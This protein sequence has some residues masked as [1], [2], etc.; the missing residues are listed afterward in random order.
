MKLTSTLLSLA[1]LT[2]V[3]AFADPYVLLGGAAGTVDMGAI[4]NVYPSG[5][6]VS[7]NFT[8]VMAG[9]GGRVNANLGVEASY[10]SR[11][12]NSVSDNG[13]KDNFSHD[14]VQFALLGFL[15]VAQNVSLFGKVSANYLDTTYNTNAALTP[16]G[17]YSEDNS[18]TYL[19]FGGGLEFN[20][21][22]NMSLRA[23]V[24]QIQIR[25]AV[26]S[27]A[28]NGNSGDFNVNQGSLGLLL[29]F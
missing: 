26:S 4:E 29:Y 8:R 15:P 11:V 25:N 28:L 23:T 9:I 20:I 10:M 19:G 16:S 21:A 12:T 22:Q 6:S 24:E 18:K 2:P 17:Y 13:F 5:A 14:G 7:D 27:S 1:L 3:A